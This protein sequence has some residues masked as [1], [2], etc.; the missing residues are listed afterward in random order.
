MFDPPMAPNV[1]LTKDGKLFENLE[2]YKRLVGKLN[3]LTRI[4]LIK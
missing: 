2:R 3:Y 4:L 1:Q